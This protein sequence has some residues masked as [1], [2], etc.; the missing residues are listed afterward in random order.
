[1]VYQV[2]QETFINNR[3]GYGAAIA[4]IMF[5]VVLAITVA[6]LQLQRRMEK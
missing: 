4:T 2:Y 3:A 6:Q 1:M 5:V